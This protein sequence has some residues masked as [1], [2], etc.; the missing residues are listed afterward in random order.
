MKDPHDIIIRPV[1]SE[2][3]YGLIDAKVYTFVVASDA[4][5]IEIRQ[6]VEA[7]WPGK[8]VSKVNTLNRKG[9]S[10]R[11]RRTARRTK[12]PDR[13]HAIVTLTQDSDEIDIFEA[14]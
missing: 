2:K 12:L 6:A 5:K 11:G 10:K 7:I 14:G 8:K 4:S 3:S 1:V 13:K 9:K